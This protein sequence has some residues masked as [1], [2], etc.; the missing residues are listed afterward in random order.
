MLASE[1]YVFNPNP[2]SPDPIPPWDYFGAKSKY[3]Q[4]EQGQIISKLLGGLQVNTSN[5]EQI[6]S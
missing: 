6:I 3:T 2:M 5:N 1:R 4:A